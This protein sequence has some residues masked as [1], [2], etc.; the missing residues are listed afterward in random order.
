M[1]PKRDTV[2]GP[3]SAWTLLKGIAGEDNP[4][5]YFGLGEQQGKRRKDKWLAKEVGPFPPGHQSESG[6]DLS[7]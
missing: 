7:L 1:A 4:A 2:A 6:R 5:R 3:A